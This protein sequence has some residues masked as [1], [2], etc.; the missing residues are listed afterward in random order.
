MRLFDDALEVCEEVC[1][2][3][4]FPVVETLQKYIPAEKSDAVISDQ[5]STSSVFRSCHS[6]SEPEKLDKFAVINND[7]DCDDDDDDDDD[8]SWYFDG[9]IPVVDSYMPRNVN[10]TLG[11]YGHIAEVSSHI[12]GVYGH[13]PGIINIEAVSEFQ[14]ELTQLQNFQPE[15]INCR[16]EDDLSPGVSRSGSL[17][18]NQ[19]KREDVSFGVE[20]ETLVDILRDSRGGHVAELQS[21]VEFRSDA[22]LFGKD[23]DDEEDEFEASF[24]EAVSNS[25]KEDF[26]SSLF[27]NA[28]GTSLENCGSK[29][30][31]TSVTA[32][33]YSKLTS[34]S[35]HEGNSDLKNI[36][37]M[38][39][40]QSEAESSIKNKDIV[41][42]ES[43]SS[44][45]YKEMNRADKL[46]S[47]VS[48]KLENKNKEARRQV[49]LSEIYK[50]SRHFVNDSTD[51]LTSTTP[52]S[53]EATLTKCN[54]TTDILSAEEDC[55]R[56]Q[57][58]QTDLVH[59]LPL[60]KT[61]LVKKSE[62]CFTS[63]TSVQANPNTT[64]SGKSL[65][66]DSM[67]LKK[68]SLDEKRETSSPSKTGFQ[69]ILKTG[70]AEK[71]D[72]PCAT[73]LRETSPTENNSSS[74]VLQTEDE[75]VLIEKNTQ[76]LSKLGERLSHGKE[77][78]MKLAVEVIKSL[79]RSSG[80]SLLEEFEIHLNM[81]HT[82]FILGPPSSFSQT[83][84]G[85]LLESTASFQTAAVS[86][87][88]TETQFIVA[89]VNGDVTPEFRHAGLNNE[90]KIHR[91]IE[92]VRDFM[93]P[94][95]NHEKDWHERVIKALTTHSI[96]ILIAKGTV[97]DSIIDHCLSHNV[98]VLQNV[99]YPK[100]QLLSFATGSTL[101]T[102]LTDLREQD[103]GRPVTIETW[104]LGW[105]PSVVRQNKKR[106]GVDCVET[107]QY[108]LVRDVK[109]ENARCEGEQDVRPMNQV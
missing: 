85:L 108:V 66:R 41:N 52:P 72:L 33:A 74:T 101:V 84:H 35:G 97:K 20:D 28:R 57:I 60:R 15:M 90:L 68:T 32:R 56:T 87:V 7:D 77:L 43:L 5:D 96:G 64:Q 93:E 65:V 82:E 51:T 48:R 98:M 12:P 55:R 92:N 6:F 16:K 18:S 81:I 17:C 30:T 31:D 71:S 50:G 107:C 10:H 4:S 109:E 59:S 8:I 36:E 88:A 26:Q 46:L 53:G 69:S 42:S 91:V 9:H 1:R 103:I 104:E 67:L 22:S 95:Y 38:T 13:I 94:V 40:T 44:S 61:L 45:G 80:K 49:N 73:L 24:L 78:E 39:S 29:T 25:A 47:L 62:T 105:A 3:I 100:L 54:Y 83:I 99:A 27:E 11:V 86:R 63:K 76:L 21:V 2:D 75:T 79:F 102:Y 58:G 106:A 23:L 14:S 89:L 19:E 37:Q 70:Q 34:V